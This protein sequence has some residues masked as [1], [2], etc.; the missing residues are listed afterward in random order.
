MNILIFSLLKLLKCSENDLTKYVSENVK[1]SSKDGNDLNVST[2]ICK[3][4][5]VAYSLHV[6]NNCTNI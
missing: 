3:L 1:F 2:A 4:Y 5:E 6:N